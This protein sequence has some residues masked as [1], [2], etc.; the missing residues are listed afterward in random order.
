[1]GISQ[2]VSTK[3]LEQ[4]STVPRFF[5]TKSRPPTVSRSIF[6]SDE[7]W[8]FKARINFNYND[9]DLKTINFIL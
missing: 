9:I 6:V 3:P 4:R 8:I 5:T 2:N 7:M 1:M